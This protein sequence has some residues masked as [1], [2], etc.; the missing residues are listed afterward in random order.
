MD[1]S[2][3]R[4]LSQRSRISSVSLRAAR[5]RLNAATRHCDWRGRLPRLQGFSAAL[6]TVPGGR[7]VFLSTGPWSRLVAWVRA[8][9]V[10]H[11]FTVPL[12]SHAG[13][14]ASGWLSASVPQHCARLWQYVCRGLGGLC[15][16]K[17]RYK[18]KS[19][20]WHHRRG[21]LMLRFGHS[22]LVAVRAYPGVRWRRQG[23]MK[24]LIFGSN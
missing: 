1:A 10:G 19:F 23:R 21:A 7:T 18:G 15:R 17:L 9:R 3:R 2:L 22:H 11:A 12:V 24:I 8:P 14:Q 16:L 13:V 20:K 5:Q 6:A 4:R